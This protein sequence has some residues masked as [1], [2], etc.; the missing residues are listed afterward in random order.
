V[1]FVRDPHSSISFVPFGL[2]ELRTGLP[3]DLRRWMHSFAGS[4]AALGTLMISIETMPLKS[5]KRGVSGIGGFSAGDLNRIVGC[6]V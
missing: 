2:G 4:A 1:L 3:R 5:G 6:A